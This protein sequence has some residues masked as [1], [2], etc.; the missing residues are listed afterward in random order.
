MTESFESG[1]F[2]LPR[3]VKKDI[4]TRLNESKR[5][6]GLEFHFK[7]EDLEGSREFAEMLV[8]LKKRGVKISH[9]FSIKLDFPQTISRRRTLALVENMPKPVNGSMKARIYTTEK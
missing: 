7:G 9:E 6:K 3:D 5:I 4:A 2:V 1:S 8:L